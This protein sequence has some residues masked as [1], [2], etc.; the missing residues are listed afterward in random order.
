MG[1]RIL[2]CLAR[3][4]RA[5]VLG[6]SVGAGDRGGRR[7]G[8]LSAQGRVLRARGSFG[9]LV[10]TSGTCCT[11]SFLKCVSEHFEVVVLM[12]EARLT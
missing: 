8:G 9:E 4:G 5:R 1:I 7:V 12:R 11:G 2:L 6:M 10:N 3:C